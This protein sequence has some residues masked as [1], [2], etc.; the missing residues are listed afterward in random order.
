MVQETCVYIPN[1]IR[2]RV[3]VKPWFA[4]GLWLYAA[5]TCT[6]F[7]KRALVVKKLKARSFWGMN[8]RVLLKTGMVV[9]CVLLLIR[10][11]H[12]GSADFA[13]KAIRTF[14]KHYVLPVMVK[15]TGHCVKK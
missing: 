9:S 7:Q 12:V 14:A 10:R 4:L 5:Q 8:F 15:M 2:Y 11:C 3:R 6:G 13:G 1:P